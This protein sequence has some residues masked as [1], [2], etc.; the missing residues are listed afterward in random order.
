MLGIDTIAIMK[1]S[2]KAD[3]AY[4][5]INSLFDPHVQAEVA[6]LKKGSPVVTRRQARSGDRQAARCLHHR[7]PVEEAGDHHRPQAA[8]GKDRG[9]AQMVRREHHELTARQRPDP[10]MRPAD[11]CVAAAYD[12]RHRFCAS[13]RHPGGAVC[14]WP[15]GRAGRGAA[16]QPARLCAGFAR[17]RRLHARQFHRAPEAALCAG[18][19][20]IRCGSASSPHSSRCVR[21]AIRSPTRWC[22]HTIGALKSDASWSSP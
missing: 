14:R 11:P 7:R 8:R 15:S 18:C 16:V 1:G 10:H 12:S 22:T 3:L 9:M 19:S 4:K 20:S 6:K 2:K 21:Q 13:F 17:G 5:F